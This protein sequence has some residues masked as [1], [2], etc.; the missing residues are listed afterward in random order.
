VFLKPPVRQRPQRLR[1]LQSLRAAPRRQPT[2]RESVSSPALSKR[3]SPFWKPAEHRKVLQR[4]R[5]MR[6]YFERK[7]GVPPAPLRKAES[8][9]PPELPWYLRNPESLP[10]RWRITL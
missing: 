10:R 3:L 7:G 5:S 1:P 2:R 6:E 9:T 4:R 8:G